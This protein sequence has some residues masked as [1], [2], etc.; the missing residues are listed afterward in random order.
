MIFELGSIAPDAPWRAMDLWFAPSGAHSRWIALK[1]G[2]EIYIEA[3][4][5]VE[6][7]AI[8][9]INWGG[10]VPIA[11]MTNVITVGHGVPVEA[12]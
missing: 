1:A 10:A 3:D 2:E 7:L 8:A 11:G 9:E 6:A 12:E 5:I 4:S